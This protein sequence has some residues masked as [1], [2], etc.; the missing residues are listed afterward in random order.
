MWASYTE[1]QDVMEENPK[2]TNI[3][4]IIVFAKYSV[5]EQLLASSCTQRSAAVQHQPTLM[6]FHSALLLVQLALCDQ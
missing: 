4:A 2:Y 1:Y 5:G 3:L 6:L